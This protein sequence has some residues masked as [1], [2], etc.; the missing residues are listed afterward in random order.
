MRLL[1]SLIKKN[2]ISLKHNLK[3]NATCRNFS[4]DLL[5]TPLPDVDKVL[6][7]AVGHLSHLVF[8]FIFLDIFTQQHGD[9]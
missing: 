7:L 6:A 5:T 8:L 4:N 2:R 1:K 3:F 9:K